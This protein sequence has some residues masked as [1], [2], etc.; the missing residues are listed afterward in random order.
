MG[1]QMVSIFFNV[2]CPVFSLVLMGYLLGPRLGIQYQSLSRTA[3]YI[4]VPAFIF[5]L[6]GHI[7]IDPATI[8]RMVI[9]IGSVYI[10]TGLIGYF[11]AKLIGY[12]R[13]TA[14]AFLMSC[15]FGNVGNYGLALTGFRL[16]D[17]AMESATVY[18]VSVNTISFSLCVLAASWLSKGEAGA[19][20]SLAKTPG[21][22]ALP[23]ALIFPFT[24]TQPPVMIER[25]T[26]LLGDAMIPV[27]LLVLGLQ[28]RESGKLSFG[29]PVLAACG[30]RLIVG[31][32]LAFV[33]F[34]IMGLTGL[35]ASAGILQAS[36]PTAVLTA[37]IA[38]EHDVLPSFVTSVVFASTLLSLASL[39]VVMLLL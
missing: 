31:P 1:F 23:I 6:L 13:K 7:H 3:Y 32:A 34:P 27:M 37:I 20:K 24:G 30:I 38:L 2:V 22:V 10:I 35:Q 33:L 21:I 25:I 17:G 15:I 14:V 18:M 8:G 5:N 9:C 26:S 39:T 11:F 4:L 16:G 29:K 12:D 28:L 36:M 19:L